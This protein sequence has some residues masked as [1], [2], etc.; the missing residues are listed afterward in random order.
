MRGSR[1][2]GRPGQNDPRSSAIES[3]SEEAVKRH[4]RKA[5][6]KHPATVVS[7]ILSILFFVIILFTSPFIGPLWAIILLI[8]SAIASVG[9]FFWRYS[10][11][12]ELEYEKRTLELLEGQDQQ[13]GQREQ[14]QLQR[15]KNDIQTGFSR[16][17]SADGLKALQELVYEYEQLQPVLD[18]GRE[19]DP[20]AVA[21]IPAL[22]EETYRQGLGVLS[23]CLDLMREI[24]SPSNR[25]LEAEVADLE[26]QISAMEE[27]D[28]QTDR[29]SIL[30]AT[31][32]SHKERLGLVKQQTLRVDGL[33]HQSDSCEASLHRTR[34]ELAAMKAD[35][36]DARVSS[37]T[38]A[39]QSTIN[40]A[41]EVQ[42]E[43]KRLGY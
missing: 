41:K 13:A 31:V 40:Q 6:L 36:V 39:L 22:A 20:V 10:L 42:E 17:N 1:R 27:N 34:I 9:A 23:G 19:T 7:L 43:L 2:S 18:R 11:R 4:V 16:V 29:L 12:Y 35:N 37:L 32:A 38:G 26:N 33:L 28:A 5:A 21:H 25:K 8:I 14:T 3:L 30:K 24:H 15:L